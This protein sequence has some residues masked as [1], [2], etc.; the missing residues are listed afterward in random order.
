M[1]P[2]LLKKQLLLFV[3]GFFLIL[4]FV[5]CDKKS[6]ASEE[7]TTPAAP[8]ADPPT[9]AMADVYN[10][11]LGDIVQGV[12]TT[13]GWEPLR[14]LPSPINVDG[15]WTDSITVNSKGNR[16]YFAYSKVNFSKLYYQSIT[17]T[18]GPQRTGMVGDDFRM[19]S[20][21]LTPDGWVVNYLPI[22]STSLD[23]VDASMSTNANEDITI[24]TRWL[25]SIPGTNGDLYFTT[26]SGAS[27][28]TPQAVPINTQCIDDNAFIVGNFG[29][30]IDMY[31]ESDRADDAGST[32][33]TATRKK[34]HIFHTVYNNQ[35]FSSV[36]LV[37]GVNGTAITDED[38]QPSLSQDQNTMYWTGS[39]SN[40][41]GIFTAT[42]S[43]G[44]FANARPI[45]YPNNFAP[46]FVGKLIMIGEANVADVPGGQV[47]YLMCGIATSENSTS[48]TGVKLQICFTKRKI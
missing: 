17:E 24:Y 42:K 28:S 2:S 46:P 15:G 30:V 32:C 34:H 26:K 1:K 4:T 22:N 11:P 5:N 48:P 33:N 7:N 47:M 45:I 29:G 36:E 23:D 14:L 9:A 41:Y 19:F 38:I 39:R 3:A 43:N 21:D 31:F 44:I 27:W 10:P 40:A 18:A 35:S 12:T 6:S 13:E 8:T 20:A 16:I 37:P 25:K